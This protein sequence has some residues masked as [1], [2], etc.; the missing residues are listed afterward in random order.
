MSFVVEP[1]DERHD[2]TWFD[3]GKPVLDMW[4]RNSA[5]HAQ[6]NRTSRTFV[7]HTG[8]GVVVA[9]YSLAAHLLTRDGIGRIGRG[10]PDEIPAVLLARLALSRGLHGQGLGSVLLADA[11]R[12]AVRAGQNVGARF[13]VVDAL[14]V[15]AAEFYAKHGFVTV[16]HDAHR[17]VRKMNDIAADVDDVP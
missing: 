1:F 14:D 9:F 15:A 4:L 16:P 2:A 13:V 7:W 12:R 3:S 8:D 11:L 5:R 10:S 6:R 17:L